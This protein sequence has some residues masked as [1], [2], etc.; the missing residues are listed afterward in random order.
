MKPGEINC[1]LSGWK[2]CEH[3]F[4]QWNATTRTFVTC[5]TNVLWKQPWSEP[6]R[7]RLNGTVGI[8]LDIRD[9]WS[10]I[11]W[12]SQHREN[13][14]EFERLWCN[15][16]RL[17]SWALRLTLWVV[18]QLEGMFNT[19]T[20]WFYSELD[21]TFLALISVSIF[22]FIKIPAKFWNSESGQARCF[23]IKWVR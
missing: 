20:A 15:W 4:E 8:I 21:E 18:I 23:P 6:W 7:P 10:R 12:I 13:C 9:R 22:P 2:I 5:L 3:E 1:R 16:S 19:N 17:N 14:L 11:R